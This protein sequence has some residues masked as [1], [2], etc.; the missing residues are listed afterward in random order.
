MI[1]STL[2]SFNSCSKGVQQAF[3]SS[4]TGHY[5]GF[6]LSLTRRSGHEALAECG[7]IINSF[8]NEGLKGTGPF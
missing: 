7:M 3:S 4:W 8:G 2:H 6:Q 5:L 1:D